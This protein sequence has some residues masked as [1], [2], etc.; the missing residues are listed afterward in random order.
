MN[1][2][3][4]RGLRFANDGVRERLAIEKL[5]GNVPFRTAD[6]VGGAVPVLRAQQMELQI[7]LAVFGESCRLS[8]GNGLRDGD[9]LRLQDGLGGLTLPVHLDVSMAV[10]L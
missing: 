1:A 3:L 5:D 7:R 10:Q 4:S 6:P 9:E 8:V 2:H